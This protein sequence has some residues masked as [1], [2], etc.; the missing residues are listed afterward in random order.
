MALVQR[1]FNLDGEK[2]RLINAEIKRL[3]L[4]KTFHTPS[5]F[6]VIRGWKYMHPYI[7]FSR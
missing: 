5:A 1:T 6:G 7:P 2:V 3:C 4:P